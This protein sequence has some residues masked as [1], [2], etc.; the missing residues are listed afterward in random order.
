MADHH[1][2]EALGKAY[3][4]R[5]MRRLL[6]YLRPY[7]ARVVAAVVLA[8]VTGSLAAVVPYLFKV[9]VDNY[10]VPGIE[11]RIDYAA[12]MTGLEWVAVIFLCALVLGFVLGYAQMLIMQLVG[13]QVM[14]DL[15][16]EIFDHL[17]R[18]P[19]SFYDRNPVGRLLTRVTSSGW[20]SSSR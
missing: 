5:L 14:F 9:G 12:A 3:D 19:L 7:R 2:E 8:L 10:L 15:R 11:H 18:L 4:A 1:E 6:R 17:Q 13:Q 20:R 16:R